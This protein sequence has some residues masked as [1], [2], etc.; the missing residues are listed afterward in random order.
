MVTGIPST[1]FIDRDG[2]VVSHWT[3]P[4]SQQQLAARLDELLR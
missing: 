4:I 1:F 2:R 3:G